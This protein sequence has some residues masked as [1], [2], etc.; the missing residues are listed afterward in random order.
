MKYLNIFFCLWIAAFA[1][2]TT[3][4]TNAA[5]PRIDNFSAW[6]VLHDGRVKTMESFSRSIFYA[7]AGTDHL[8]GIDATTWMANTLFDPASTISEPFIKINRQ[9]ILD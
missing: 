1:T 3:T 7:I 2:M 6:S 5:E 8:N 9:T 4:Q